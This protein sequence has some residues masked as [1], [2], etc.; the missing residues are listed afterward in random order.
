RFSRD[1]S[2]D[3]CSSDLMPQTATQHQPFS[4]F[5]MKHRAL[6][7]VSFLGLLASLGWNGPAQA[8]NTDRS[9][10]E[11]ACRNEAVI[12]CENWEDGD[13]VGWKDYNAGDSRSEEH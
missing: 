13:W 2:S 5:S 4:G 6:A 12:F 8:E 9:K 10:A 7:A 11:P 3:V 1:W